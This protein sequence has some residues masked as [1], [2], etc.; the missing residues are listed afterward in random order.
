MTVFIKVNPAIQLLGIH[1]I[2]ILMCE[3]MSYSFPYSL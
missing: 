3:I 2:D 1:P